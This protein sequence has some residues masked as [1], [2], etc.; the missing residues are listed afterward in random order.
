MNLNF[1][2]SV[3]VTMLV[4]N[5]ITVE[6]YKIWPDRSK[7]RCWQGWETIIIMA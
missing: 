6:S 4:S 1:I 3:G 2:M 5:Y 7:S